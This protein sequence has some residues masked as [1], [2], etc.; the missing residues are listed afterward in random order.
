[1]LDEIVE[2]GEKDLSKEEVKVRNFRAKF[3]G[4][5]YED[6]LEVWFKQ[7]GYNVINRDVRRGLYK[8]RCN[9]LFV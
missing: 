4:L 5:I 7:T 3:L 8:G 2:L 1:M 6:L 9:I